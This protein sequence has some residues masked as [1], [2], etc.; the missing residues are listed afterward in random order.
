MLETGCVLRPNSPDAVVV[1]AAATAVDET[2]VVTMTDVTSVDMMTSVMMIGGRSRAPLSILRCLSK[3][4]VNH[5]H[6]L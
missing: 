1:A 5:D 3:F 4:L 6:F 2:S